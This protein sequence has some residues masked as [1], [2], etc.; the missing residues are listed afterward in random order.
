ML[1]KASTIGAT[2]D[3][4]KQDFLFVINDDYT[5]HHLSDFKSFS[6]RELFMRAIEAERKLEEAKKELEIKRAQYTVASSINKSSLTSEILQ[7]E[8]LI[9]E[10]YDQWRVTKVVTR[11]EEI[12]HINALK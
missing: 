10:L 9:G 1:N 7:M 11:N 3:T 12:R 2:N 6:A 4:K 8:K 5:Y